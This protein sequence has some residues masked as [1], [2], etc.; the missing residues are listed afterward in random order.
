MKRPITV[1]ELVWKYMSLSQE[2][3]DLFGSDSVVPVDDLITALSVA[4]QSMKIN[5]DMGEQCSV[6]LKFLIDNKS[7]FES[8]DFRV[9]INGVSVSLN[10]LTAKTKALQSKYDEVR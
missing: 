9:L 3:K 4:E 10:L 1:T 2:Q 5:C 6:L 7:K 8:Q